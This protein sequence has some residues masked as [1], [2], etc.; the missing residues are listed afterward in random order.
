MSYTY[1]QVQ[2]TTVADNE[3][4]LIDAM[5]NHGDE[6]LRLIYSY[7]KNREVAEDLTQDVFI[8]VYQRIDQF[9]QRSTLRTWLYRIAIN[10]SKDYLKSWHFRKVHT[11]EEPFFL[12][13]H[14]GRTPEQL[15]IQ[16]SETEAI[17][18]KVFLLPLK[19]RE[20][21]YLFYYQECSVKEVAE[22]LQLKE[23]TVK[24]RL[25]QARKKMK[26]SYQKE[27]FS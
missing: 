1:E 25:Y 26:L 20:V 18:E 11:E 10:Q 2:A 16:Q 15:T 24:T 5:Q 17:I 13:R 14:D 3:A 7:V 6:I 23:A 22:L 12:Q 27:D 19:Y 8:K 9:Q 4:I 21:I